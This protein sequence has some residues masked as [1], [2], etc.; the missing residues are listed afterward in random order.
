VIPTP[1]LL[2]NLVSNHLAIGFLLDHI[3]GVIALVPPVGLGVDERT[4]DCE[5][6]IILLIRKRLP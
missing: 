3:G 4:L 1:F 2:S 6:L 5:F